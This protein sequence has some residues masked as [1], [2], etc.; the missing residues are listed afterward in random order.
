[1]QTLAK[2]ADSLWA[3]M[4]SPLYMP[5]LSSSFL[6]SAKPLGGVIFIFTWD[7]TRRQFGNHYLPSGILAQCMVGTQEVNK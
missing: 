5:S 6:P 3:Q 7:D 2:L 1:M 4:P